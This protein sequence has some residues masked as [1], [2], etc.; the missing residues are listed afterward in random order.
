[1]RLP[2]LGLALVSLLGVCNRERQDRPG[3][4]TVTSST[5]ELVPNRM[6]LDR[7][8]AAQCVREQLCVEVGLADEVA[9]S[10]AD[11]ARTATCDGSIDLR[12][13]E[14]CLQAIYTSSCATEFEV[15]GALDPCKAHAL[16]PER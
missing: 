6:A 2:V 10:C 9:T 11:R 15:R 14:E 12:R 1:M 4:T 3:E 8:I 7:I 5:L 16:C 13:L